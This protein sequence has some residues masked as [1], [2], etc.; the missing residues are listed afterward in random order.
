MNG[1]SNSDDEASP[2]FSVS[3]DVSDNE[4]DD[5]EHYAGD[6]STRFQELMSDADGG[7]HGKHGHD[8]GEDDEEDDDDDEEE[9]VYTGVDAE[10]AGDY[11]S[12]LK[13][14]LGSDHEDDELELQHAAIERTL[15][16]QV[17]ENE[18]FAALLE[19]EAKVSSSYLCVRPRLLMM[20]KYQRVEVLTP[21]SSISRSRAVSPLRQSQE[22]YIL[23]HLKPVKPFLHPS[24]S[25]L[26]S[27]T[28]QTSRAPSASSVA[29]LQ[30]HAHGGV[31][32]ATSHFSAL[33]RTASSTDLTAGAGATLGEDGAQHP[34]HPE[35]REVFR[36]TD[37]RTVGDYLYINP[38]QKASALLGA[39]YAGSPTVLAANGLICVGTDAGRV[40]VFDF[41]QNLKC[42]CGAESSGT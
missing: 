36:W 5:G 30:S 41:K 12:Q 3:P 1:T 33:S 2:G 13:D 15:L 22:G 38:S 14:V 25:R 16:Q 23:P 31:S 34:L 8:G 37:L 35:A 29:T 26:R 9:F 40:L 11:R 32:A 20:S 4:P 10:P 42:T 39:Q 17:E 7:G 28:P 27:T 18:K 19:D 24:I 6:Y 21:S